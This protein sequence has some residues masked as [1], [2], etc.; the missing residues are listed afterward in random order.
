M[1]EILI[2][3]LR[4]WLWWHPT[5][6]RSHVSLALE[7]LGLGGYNFFRSLSTH[8]ACHLVRFIAFER[9]EESTWFCEGPLVIS[10]IYTIWNMSQVDTGIISSH[11]IVGIPIYV[12]SGFWN[13]ARMCVLA[14]P[15]AWLKH[16][17]FMGRMFP[18]HCGRLRWNLVWKMM[19]L[20]NWVICRFRPL[21][22]QWVSD[23]ESL[24]FSKSTPLGSKQTGWRKLGEWSSSSG[25]DKP[26]LQRIPSGAKEDYAPKI[27]T[28]LA[29]SVKSWFLGWQPKNAA[30][31]AKVRI[32]K[33]FGPRCWFRPL[34]HLHP[35]PSQLLVGPHSQISKIDSSWGFF[36]G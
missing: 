25:Y 14:S 26:G 10:L 17:C 6:K 34:K 35:E 5:F 3:F 4:C 22:F 23:S 27:T 24:L 13:V 9:W 12:M 36:W 33:R 2:W 15:L 20:L 7:D 28:T 19:F 31:S 29:E 11:Y 18:L 30:Y 32:F 1:F 8:R 16:S 21:I